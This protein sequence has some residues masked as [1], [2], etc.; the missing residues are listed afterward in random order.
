MKKVAAVIGGACVLLGGLWLLQGMGIVHL[1]PLLCFADCEA[2]QGPSL[3]WAITGLFSVTAGAL[4]VLY[5]VR[6][7]ARG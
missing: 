5:S 4:L 3:Q 2:I 6:G 7:S 1:R